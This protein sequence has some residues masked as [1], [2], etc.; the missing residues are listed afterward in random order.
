MSKLLVTSSP[1]AKSPVTTSRIMLDVVISL[2]PALVAAVVI[3]GMRALLVVSV[4]VATCVISEL[5]YEKL[6]KR[7]VTINDFSAV[8]TGVLLAYNLP[9]RKSVV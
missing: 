8:V 7:P 9:D 4:C 1:H 3:F 5:A 2:V 6:M